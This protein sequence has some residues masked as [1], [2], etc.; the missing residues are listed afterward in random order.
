MPAIVDIIDAVTS[1]PIAALNP[2]LD[3][4]GPYGPGD[5]T[6]T[7]FSTNGA[8]LLPAGTYSISGTYGVIVNVNGV[9]PPQ[10]GFDIGWNDVS[11]LASGDVY[12][13]RIAQVAMMHT[14]PISGA[15][16]IFELAD[17]KT[18]SQLV[19]SPLL[20]GSALTL[21]LHVEPNWHVDLFYLCVL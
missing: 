4:G 12:E 7:T 14:L 15:K 18:I 8:F 2:V 21:G 10:A 20:V 6:L 16:L 3:T 5:H 11:I 9:I 13:D 19:Y 17:I 1:P